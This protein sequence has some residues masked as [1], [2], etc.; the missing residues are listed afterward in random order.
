MIEL[1]PAKLTWD[2]DCDHCQARW[3]VEFTDLRWNTT[4]TELQFICAVCNEPTW[5][6]KGWFS[7]YVLKLMKEKLV[8]APKKAEPDRMISDKKR[9]LYVHQKIPH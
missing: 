8:P 6:P 5:L 2:S 7:P 3:R 4:Q 1:R 9:G